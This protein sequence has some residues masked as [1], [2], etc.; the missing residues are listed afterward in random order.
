MQ[1]RRNTNDNLVSG[2]AII[3]SVEVSKSP[4]SKNLAH[5]PCKFF[6][7][8]A[9]Q[10][11]DS[12]PF[13]HVLDS[14]TDTT[15]CKYFQKGNCKFGVKCAL[16]HILPDGR[17]VNPKSLAQVYQNHN[18]QNQNSNKGFF[19]IN[20]TSATSS[21][22]IVQTTTSTESHNLSPNNSYSYGKN[23]SNDLNSYYSSV[24]QSSNGSLTGTS[25]TFNN[26]YSQTN[27]N[28][29]FPETSPSY[30]RTYTNERLSYSSIWNPTPSNNGKPTFRS[31][32]H[33][34]V[35]RPFVA[36]YNSVDFSESAIL[37]DEYDDENDVFEEDF[38]PSS[39]SD[40]LT[41]QEL[42]RRG[43][44]PSSIS[45][46]FLNFNVPLS[47][48]SLV[49]SIQSNQTEE[50]EETQFKMDDEFNHETVFKNSSSP[51]NVSE[52]RI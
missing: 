30:Q 7:Q 34:S 19:S 49:E 8:G 35:L 23:G 5:V 31:A 4:P 21:Q 18:I 25:P 38:V 9:C 33:S 6:K 37:D 17:R 51:H 12:C 52:L 20:T 39:L 1:T 22:N 50:I 13:S 24:N 15:P 16:A 27:P 28:L 14:T 2:T 36:P 42:Q 29:V 46:P 48:Q 11:G 43:S 40:L 47:S 26:S 3:Q 41:P 44:R 10:A 45:K 32:S